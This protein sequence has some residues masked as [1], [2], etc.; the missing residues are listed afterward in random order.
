M[1]NPIWRARRCRGQRDCTYLICKGLKR[2]VGEEVRGR[3][4][5]RKGERRKKYETNWKR[6]GSGIAWKERENV[7]G[8][9]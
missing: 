5:E 3:G 6:T 2:N 7:T 4:G 9:V 1:G 8:Y